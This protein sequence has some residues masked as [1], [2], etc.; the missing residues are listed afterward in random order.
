MT[1][2]FC[3]Y[4]GTP[5]FAVRAL[6]LHAEGEVDGSMETA[7]CVADDSEGLSRR[8]PMTSSKKE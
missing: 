6:P 2:L 5:S 4:C 8:L 1:Q 3:Q 7:A